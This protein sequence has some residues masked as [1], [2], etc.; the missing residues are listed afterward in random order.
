[1]ACELRTWRGSMK[2]GLIHSCFQLATMSQENILS[3][4]TKSSGSPYHAEAQQEAGA[5]RERALCVLYQLHFTPSPKS[6]VPTWKA[7]AKMLLAAG[8]SPANHF[9]LAPMSQSTS[10]LGQ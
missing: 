2:R 3:H 1:M 7:R 5:D 8:T 4:K 10:A 6:N 9:D